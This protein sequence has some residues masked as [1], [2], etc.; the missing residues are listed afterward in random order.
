LGRGGTL[1]RLEKPFLG[2]FY[3]LIVVSMILPVLGEFLGFVFYSYIILVVLVIFAGVVQT[4]G[5][6]YF[7][8]RV[9][10]ILK[11]STKEL[12][13]KSKSQKVVINLLSINRTLFFFLKKK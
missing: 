3:T 12:G 1:K 11:K 4:V 13:T 7:G 2:T 5:F 6:L 8:V 10:F 9:L